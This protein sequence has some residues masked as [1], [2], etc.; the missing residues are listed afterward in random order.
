MLG[1][2][3]NLGR[4]DNITYIPYFLNSSFC[5]LRP[6]IT[7]ARQGGRSGNHQLNQT[8]KQVTKFFSRTRLNI[9]YYTS[10]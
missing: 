6:Q 2:T 3:L 10:F 9:H 4:L 7:R 5:H 8:K 1:Q